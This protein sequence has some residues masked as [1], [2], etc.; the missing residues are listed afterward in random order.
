MYI[1]EYIKHP[2]SPESHWFET[3]SGQLSLS[4]FE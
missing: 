1:D 3:L 2:K 4:K